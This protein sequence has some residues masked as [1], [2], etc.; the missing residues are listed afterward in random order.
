M[1]GRSERHNY[2][3]IRFYRTI[4]KNAIYIVPVKFVPYLYIVPVIFLFQIKFFFPGLYAINGG[5]FFLLKYWEFR[6]NC[7][8]TVSSGKC[9][10]TLAVPIR[11]WTLKIRNSDWQSRTEHEN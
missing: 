5:F 2:Y 8:N 11:T 7:S 4:I 3:S 1:A 10:S 9:T 6:K